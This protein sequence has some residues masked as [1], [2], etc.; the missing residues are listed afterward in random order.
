MG[1]VAVIPEAG[2]ASIYS[3]TAASHFGVRVTLTHILG[4]P[5]SS[6][7]GKPAA[8]PLTESQV[9][10]VLPTLRP[11][12]EEG[13]KEVPPWPR[14]MHGSLE[15]VTGLQPAATCVPSLSRTAPAAKGAGGAASG[16]SAKKGSLRSFNMGTE[17]GR[18]MP[19][20]SSKK[21]P[22]AGATET[23]VLLPT[24]DGEQFGSD[25]LALALSTS[26]SKS[27]ALQPA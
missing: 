21:E 16:G 3:A 6:L 18:C 17:A 10:A 9:P 27:H 1:G 24:E 11:T 12:E 2:D 15:A 25:A 19:P 8:S 22:P 23:V 7:A 4:P 20:R 5:R 13:L 14:P 26:V